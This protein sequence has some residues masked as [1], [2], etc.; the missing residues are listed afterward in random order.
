MKN[1]IEAFVA[2]A[3]EFTENFQIE[4][5]R[6]RVAEYLRE[7]IS[8]DSARNFDYLAEHG[9]LFMCLS[10][11]LGYLEALSENIDSSNTNEET[12]VITTTKRIKLSSKRIFV[13]H[14]HDNESKETVSRFQ[15]LISN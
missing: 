11:Q 2:Q 8:L 6:Y 1:K 10:K 13:V 5:W 4:R 15:V 9:D 14:G 7:A 12:E 3:E